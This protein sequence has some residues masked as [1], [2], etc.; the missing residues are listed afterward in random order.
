MCISKK[1]KSNTLN[2][3]SNNHTY[4]LLQF[5]RR[6]TFA[7]L[8]AIEWV[9]LVISIL[10]ILATAVMTAA[11]LYVVVKET[12]DQPLAEN[13]DFVFCILLLVNGCK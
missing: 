13:V 11:R 5:Q 7:G 4:F 3:L 2:R 10:N 1:H 8:L 12:D 6:R 9:F